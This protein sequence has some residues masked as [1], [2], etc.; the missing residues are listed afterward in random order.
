MLGVRALPTEKTNARTTDPATGIMVL[1][2]EQAS[3][4]F[5]ESRRWAVP[6]RLNIFV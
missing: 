3:G 1:D 4:R 6:V 5:P 2:G